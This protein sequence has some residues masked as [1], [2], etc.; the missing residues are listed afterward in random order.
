VTTG[1]QDLKHAYVFDHEIL[2]LS[3][4][5]SNPSDMPPGSPELSPQELFINAKITEEQK[6]RELL[7][8]HSDA[9]EKSPFLLGKDER[10]SYRLFS[11]HCGSPNNMRISFLGESQYFSGPEKTDR[12]ALV[13]FISSMTR[14]RCVPIRITVDGRPFDLSDTTP[15]CI[16][17]DCEIAV[18]LCVLGGNNKKKQNQQPRKQ[19]PAAVNVRIRGRGDYSSDIQKAATMA[20]RSAMPT[21]KS[22]AKNLITDTGE[23]LGKKVGLGSFGKRMA[24]RFS[25]L[26]GAGDYG[27][28]DTPVT[29][30]LFPGS[31]SP[32]ATASFSNA[33]ITVPH[34]EYIQDINT[35]PN[36]GI[37]NIE[38]WSVNP[39]LSSFSP[40]LAALAGNFEEYHFKGLV[41]EFVSTTS[42]Y[43]SNSAIGSIII[44]MSYNAAALPFSNKTQM[45]NSDFALS[46][47]FDGC[48]LYG[49]ECALTMQ[50]EYLVRQQNN[51]DIPVTTT[52]FGTL[53]VAT[54]PASTFPVLSVIGEL[55]V[56]FEVILSKPR[57]S[58]A[59]F[60][61]AHFRGTQPYNLTGDYPIINVSVTGQPA[62][63]LLGALDNAYLTNV[64]GT[65]LVFFPD[66]AL[67]DVY[68]V[69]ITNYMSGLP[70]TGTAPNVQSLTNFNFL[71][72]LDINSAP[73]LTA[74]ENDNGTGVGVFYVVVTDITTI[75]NIAFAPNSIVNAAGVHTFD[76]DII[77]TDLGNGFTN[78]SI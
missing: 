61:Y 36:A 65:T 23:S 53:Y 1:Q 77:F 25:K 5:E 75:P 52:D 24:A 28:N 22:M 74:I 27:V 30:S 12:T 64:G 68:Q 60:G 31:K 73:G 32:P 66:A 58:N 37:F 72:L 50:N 54:Q 76:T 8:G 29:N 18:N 71:N 7:V 3:E 26:I 4:L 55:W 62:P 51:P 14:T 42:P 67:G 6:L 35:G 11:R 69:V 78:A 46:A 63:V 41:F 20:V 33:G 21:L 70:V 38:S 17:D 44:C 56:A 39:G 16:G 43:N 40:W 45:E 48:M 49:V 2:T 9:K 13:N 19:R 57:L 10:F 34:R 59:R 47:R 15:Y